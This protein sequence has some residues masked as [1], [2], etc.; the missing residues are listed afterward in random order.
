MSSWETEPLDKF[1]G[2]DEGRKGGGREHW[3]SPLTLRDGVVYI[4]AE[5][6]EHLSMIQRMVKEQE[7]VRELTKKLR[8]E[9]DRTY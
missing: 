7:A 6:I 2:A 8:A 9:R 4:P 3:G 5:A 1:P